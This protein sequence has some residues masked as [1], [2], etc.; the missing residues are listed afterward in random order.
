M[1]PSYRFSL[2]KTA[3][4]LVMAATLAACG[5]PE[6][7]PPAAAAP[8]VGVHTVQ[9]EPLTLVTVLP[10]RSAAFRIAEVRPQV[11]GIV[12]KR[13]FEEG[14]EVEKG[15]Q[16]YQIDDAVHQ[17][18]YDRA[19]A[20]LVTTE[21]LAKRYQRL[22]KTSAISQQQYDDAMAAWKQAQA[23]A[24][25][26]RINVVYTKVL[27]P[28]SG[29]AGRSTVSEGALVTNGQ[30]TEMVT[31]QQIDP[32]YVDVQQPVTEVLRLRK[33]MA[34]GRLE[35]AG[36]DQAKASLRLEDGSIYPHTGTLQFSEVTVDPG[37]SSVT[38]R[39]EFPNPDGDLLPGMFVQAQLNEGVRNDALLVPQQAVMRDQKGDPFV[40]VVDADSKAQRRSIVT[41]RTVGNQWLVGGGL[42]SGEQVVTEGVQRVRQ[43]MEVVAKPA[44]NVSVVMDFSDVDESASAAQTEAKDQAAVSGKP[45]TN[46]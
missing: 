32:I 17:A 37:T 11:N 22:Q 31:V 8:E 19:R 36:A 7:A 35:L 1:K 46:A 21:R 16:L 13:L 38:L 39:A 23:Q 10:G 43:G 45:D 29:R 24:E 28:I 30:A 4:L 40:W 15:Q 5:Q 6:Q 9:T 25:L 44:E 42:S 41:L 33:E 2:S 3:A 34:N 26:A 27:A 20:N 18:E 14:A 12:E